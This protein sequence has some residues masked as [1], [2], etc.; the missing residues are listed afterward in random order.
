MV[1]SVGRGEFDER[2]P[3]DN[4]QQYPYVLYSDGLISIEE[5]C[6]LETV[7]TG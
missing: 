6:A 1:E 4:G 3:S 5:Y 7:R 2:V